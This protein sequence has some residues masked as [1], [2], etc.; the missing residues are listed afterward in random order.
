[1]AKMIDAFELVLNRWA[2]S[3]FSALNSRTSLHTDDA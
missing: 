1:M 3:C 2:S